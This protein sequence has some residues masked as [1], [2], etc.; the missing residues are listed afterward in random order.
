MP[1]ESGQL[2]ETCKGD[3]YLQI[4]SHWKVFNNYSVARPWDFTY[5]VISL[6]LNISLLLLYLYGLKKGDLKLLGSKVPHQTVAT[7]KVGKWTQLAQ[8]VASLAFKCWTS[9]CDSCGKVL[10]FIESMKKCWLAAVFH[11]IILRWVTMGRL[12]SEHYTSC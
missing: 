5:A 10:L 6:S 7:K 4:E 1:S 9:S 3:K 12:I 8:C 2:T 11:Y